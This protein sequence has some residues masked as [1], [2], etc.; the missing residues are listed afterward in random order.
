VFEELARKNE[1]FLTDT[2]T[3]AQNKRLHQIGLQF[4]A[5]HQLT[6]P[7]IVKELNLSEEQLQKIKDLQKDARKALVAL[8][9]AREREGRAEKLAK[10][11]EETREKVLALLTDDQKAKIAEMAGPLFKGEIVI[12]EPDDK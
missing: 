12:E 2:L 8:L 3:P 4:T 11:R 9:Y 6:K 10:L 5:L 1:Q 7:E